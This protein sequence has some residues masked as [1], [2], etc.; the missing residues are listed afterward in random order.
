[1]P[2]PGAARAC[3]PEQVLVVIPALNE[4]AAIE[5]CI[6]S[7]RVDDRF[8][9]RV[10][11]VVA[12]GG[13]TD[14]T[15]DIV[16]RM[17]ADDPMLRLLNNPARL[18]SAGIN[19]AVK[20]EAKPEHAI[21]VRCDAH[22]VYPPGYVRRV[23]EALACRPEAASVATVMDAAGDSGF[24]RACA[25]VMD[26]PLGSGGS[27]H[28]G[29]TRPQ[30]VDHGHHAG[31]RLSWFRRIGGYNPSFSHNEDAEYDRR[32]A[33]AGGRI[34][35]AADIRLTYQVRRTPGGLRRQYW[36]YGRGRA[37]TVLTHRMRPRLRQLVPVLNVL[38]L[39]GGLAGAALWP[40]ALIWP[41]AYVAAL[42]AVSLV[43][44]LRLRG[45]AGLW[46]GAALGIMHTA[47]GLGFLRIWLPWI[48]T[49]RQ[50]P[51]YA[52]KL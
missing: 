2:P 49:R 16:K 3:S 21:L 35:L 20:R 51:T 27:Q 33:Q 7:L 23:A 30:W 10:C 17:A 6:A 37:R 19:L 4:A 18:Q 36:N 41:A 40:P 5:A 52:P 43:G 47:W 9:E 24:A 15:R 22:A 1:M 13:S 32:L 28:R 26:T 8:M 38:G 46:A 31:F 34:W 44:A 39:A 12:D 25:W 45:C 29:G 50:A 42:L 11:I 48:M 14:G